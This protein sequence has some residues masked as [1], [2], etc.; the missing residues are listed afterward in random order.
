MRR[1]K[2]E[3]KTEE[4]KG[5]SA[6]VEFDD[7]T[8][9]PTRLGILTV[10]NEC[11]HADF[12]FLKPTLGLTD[13]NLGRHLEVLERDGLVSLERRFVG[14]KPNTVVMIT[15][16]GRSALALQVERMRELVERFDNS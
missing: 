7:A 2:T 12:S 6:R 15:K 4:P 13:G 5:V 16:K 14:R 3:T 11:K 1:G 10:L 8:H 9:Q